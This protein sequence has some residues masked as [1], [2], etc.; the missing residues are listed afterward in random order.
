ML[1]VMVQ[2]EFFAESSIH[3]YYE[4][5]KTATVC[6]GCVLFGEVEPGNDHDEFA[7]CILFEYRDLADHVPI[8]TSKLFNRFLQDYG[9]IKAE[10]IGATCRYNAGPGKELELP[11]DYKLVGTFDYLRNSETSFA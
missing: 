2:Y 1:I 5:Y 3:G 9:D 4:Y 6:T 8:V 10:C 11:S 7:V